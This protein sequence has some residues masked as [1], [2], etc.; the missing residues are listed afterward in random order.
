MFDTTETLAFIVDDQ[1]F[2]ADAQ[3][4]ACFAA[5]IWYTLVT[6]WYLTQR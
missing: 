1:T 4:C 3:I 5:F 2:E 6:E